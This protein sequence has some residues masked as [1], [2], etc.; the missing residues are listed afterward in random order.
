[1]EYILPVEMSEALHNLQLPDP[2]LVT[3]YNNLENIP[4]STLYAIESGCAAF[5][6]IATLAVIIC[7][8]LAD[9][10]LL[11]GFLLP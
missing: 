5:A 9:N 7:L 10:L 8:F 4:D 6:L 11:P 1:M 2:A 3:Y